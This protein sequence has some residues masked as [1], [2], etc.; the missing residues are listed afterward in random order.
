MQD[1]RFALSQNTNEKYWHLDLINETLLNTGKKID[2]GLD[3]TRSYLLA[4]Y[5]HPKLT[6]LA[7]YHQRLV[8]NTSNNWTFNHGITVWLIHSI[9]LK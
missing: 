8:P 7:G 5:T 1:L 3:Q 4:G 9:N 2:N 6:M